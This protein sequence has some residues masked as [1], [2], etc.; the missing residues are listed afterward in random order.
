M[1][2]AIDEVGIDAGF[3]KV[4]TVRLGEIEVLPGNNPYK[5]VHNFLESACRTDL[6]QASLN[7]PHGFH[8]YEA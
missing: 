5:A 1:K 6:D 8:A 4:K 7:H 2:I 3:G